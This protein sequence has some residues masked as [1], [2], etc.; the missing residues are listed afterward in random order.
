[1]TQPTIVPGFQ[2]Y[3][4][5]SAEGF[6]AVRV[7]YPQGRPELLVWVEDAGEFTVALDA[8]REVQAGKVIVDVGRLD[9]RLRGAIARARGG[10]DGA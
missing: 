7:M 6:G 9:P 10:G 5:G 1:M 4:A 3:A 2:V 8:I